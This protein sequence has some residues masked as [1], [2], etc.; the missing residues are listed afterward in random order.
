VDRADGSTANCRKQIHAL[1]TDAGTH[2]V[3]AAMALALR[4]RFCL[5]AAV[6]RS[7]DQA[8]KRLFN[9][10]GPVM[11]LRGAAIHWSAALCMIGSGHVLAEAQQPSLP[12]RVAELKPALAASQASPRQY[13]METTVT[14]LKGEEKSLKQQRCCYG[15]D[16]VLQRVPVSASSPPEQ[17]KG[18]AW[19]HHREQEGGAFGLH[20]ERRAGEILRAARPSRIQAVRDAGKVTIEMLVSGKRVRLNFPAYREQPTVGLYGVGVPR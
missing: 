12:E 1:K 3:K 9:A 13:G 18:V 10:E 20:K 8:M 17:K 16:G 15:A 11:T 2:P 7:A 6:V 5:D 19:T 4:D 14:S